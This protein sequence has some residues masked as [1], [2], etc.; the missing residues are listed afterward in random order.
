MKTD[1]VCVE[2]F[3]RK[4][5]DEFY[6]RKGVR[7]GRTSQCKECAKAYYKQRYSVYSEEIKSKKRE[8]EFKKILNGTI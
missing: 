3:A 8:R 7:D 1:K 5:L 4:P 2:C 6:R